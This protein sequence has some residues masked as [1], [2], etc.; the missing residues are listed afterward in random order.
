M[1]LLSPVLLVGH[2][3]LL[4]MERRGFGG[5]FG[6]QVFEMGLALGLMLHLLGVSLFLRFGGNH[7]VDREDEE[8]REQNTEVAMD[9]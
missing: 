6:F 4:L 2:L 1:S 3:Q 8:K 9:Q 5:K 7:R